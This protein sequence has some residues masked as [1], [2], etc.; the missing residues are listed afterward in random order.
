MKAWQNLLSMVLETVVDGD[1][2]FQGV[3][4]AKLKKGI[5][6]ILMLARNGRRKRR[7]EANQRMKKRNMI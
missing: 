6:Y 2:I 4:E 3:S 1:K 5:N 7:K